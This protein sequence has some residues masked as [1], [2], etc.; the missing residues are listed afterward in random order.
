MLG[1]ALVRFLWQENLDVT[2]TVSSVPG[3]DEILFQVLPE[4]LLWDLKRIIGW[5]TYDYIINCIWTI[6]PNDTK[7]EIYDTFFVNSYF[8]QILWMLC[9]ENGIKC[10]HISTDCVFSWDKWMYGDNDLP[11]EVGIYGMSKFLWEIH[12]TWHLTIRTSIIGHE[13]WDNSKNLL[14]W[15]LRNPD[16]SQ[17]TWYSWV[18]W[19]GIT[20]LTL[21]QI[22]GRIITKDFVFTSG[23]I[24]IGSKKI[25]KY[26]LL[27][28]LKKEY[29]K[30]ITIVASDS[31][32]SN[33]T[34]VPSKEQ[35][36]FSDLILPLNEQIHQLATFYHHA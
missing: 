13:L 23:L 10:I 27:L 7:D 29:E 28:L 14:G 2:G 19:N 11:D 9:T 20:T 21:S 1:N 15:F 32:K 25:D 16:W 6:R 26:N 31:I 17:I 8:P 3:I 5:C 33:K 18:Y 34:I 24:Q 30:D 22:I 35:Q 36:Y 12:Q 4:S